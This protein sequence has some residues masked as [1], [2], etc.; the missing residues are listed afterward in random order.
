MKATV[1][2][3]NFLA[4]AVFATFPM[5]LLSAEP[6]N[7][8]VEL[9]TPYP[10]TKKLSGDYTISIRELA[11]KTCLDINY[12]QAGAYRIEDLKDYTTLKISPPPAEKIKIIEYTKNRTNQF[13]TE[14][15]PVKSEEHQPPYNAIFGRC[16]HFYKSKE[17]SDF[18]NQIHKKT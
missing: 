3:L 1:Y 10:P 6:T 5:R 4:I 7:L 15:L 12:E 11:L 17:L 18:I 14:N 16:I 9:K 2:A 8:E 13:Y